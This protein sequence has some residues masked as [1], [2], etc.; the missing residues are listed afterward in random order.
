MQITRMMVP[1]SKYNIKCP[2]TMKPDGICVHNTANKASAIAEIS[3]MIG[4]NNK[5]SYHYAVDNEKIVQ[6]I[7]EDRNAWHAGDGTKGKGNRNKIAIEICHSIN[8]DVSKFEA[9]EK[10]AAK[11]IAYK[12]KEKGWGIEKVSKHQDYSNKYC[13]HKTL[14][15]GWER[16][17]K[18]IEEEL[19]SN[20]VIKR[21]TTVL[22]WQ[23]AMNKS[24]KCGL[25]E[26]NS[27]GPDSKT[28][29]NKYYLHYK[30]PTI[31]N[32][33]VKFVQNRLRTLGYSIDVDSSFGPKTEDIVKQYQKSKGLTQDGY[34][35]ANTTKKLLG[36]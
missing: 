28:K 12:L 11:F 1:S 19:N 20:K 5:V 27:Y 30:T 23:R 33:H 32:E 6:G 26:D 24:Y 2:Y 34:V 10:L 4:N 13:P 17:L 21:S 16:F 8:P 22:E 36:L 18:M 14:D 25:A 35:G 9:S 29:S 15:L 3:Y 7:E 31:K